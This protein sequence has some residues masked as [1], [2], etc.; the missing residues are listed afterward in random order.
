MF[1]TTLSFVT[2]ANALPR[3][4]WSSSEKSAVSQRSGGR[5]AVLRQPPKHF[6][7]T[8]VHCL[9]E[10]LHGY[11]H[12]DSDVWLRGALLDLRFMLHIKTPRSNVQDLQVAAAPWMSNSGSPSP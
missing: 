4:L 10:S 7:E 3:Y 9:C 5:N 2:V 1:V 6:R 8:R 11:G 12:P